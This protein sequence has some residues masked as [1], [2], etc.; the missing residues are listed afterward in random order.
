MR[1]LDAAVELL[2][3]EGMRA[4]T[5]ARVDERAGL[6]PGSTSNWFRTRRAL[7]IGVVD[8]ISERERDDMDPAALF[9]AHDLDGLIDGLSTLT[10]LQ[11]E[12]YGVRTRARVALFLELA[13]DPEI[14]GRLRQQHSTFQ[15][16]TEDALTSAGFP[17]AVPATR[18]LMALLEGLILHRLVLDP[19]LDIRGAI[20]R[21]VRTLARP[22]SEDRA[23]G[24]VR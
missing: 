6:P 3:T 19:G 9:L 20:E 5:H 11:V 15:Q 1:A 21:A 16:W 13:D 24:Q 23:K 14:G 17:D 7:L 10:Q 8:W 2:G 4:L 12:P 18:A 22:T